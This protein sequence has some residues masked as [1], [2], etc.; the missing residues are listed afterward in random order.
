MSI[1]GS[2]DFAEY[3]KYILNNNS[4]KNDMVEFYLRSIL[5]T[6]LNIRLLMSRLGCEVGEHLA[7]APTAGNL[8][9][10]CHTKQSLEN[11]NHP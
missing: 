4:N 2:I 9:P 8:R 11:N 5:K 3:G 7:T 6:L 1:F 10:V